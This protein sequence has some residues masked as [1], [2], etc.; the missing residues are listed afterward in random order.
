MAH[1]ITM[2][3]SANVDFIMSLPHLPAVGESLTADSFTQTFGGKGSNQAIA[4]KRSGSDVSLIVSIGGDSLGKTLL[5]NYRK[6][7]FDTTNVAV[8]EDTSC[9]TCLIFFDKNGDNM[10]AFTRLAN[11][12]L[13][14]EQVEKAEETIAAS[15]ILMMQMEIPEAPMVKAIEL[16]KKHG[17]EVMMNYAPYMKASILRVEGNVDILV[18]NE[19]EASQMLG[20]FPVEN[21]ESAMAA[22]EKLAKDG[23]RLTIVTLGANGSVVCEK[24]A[25][26]HFPPFKVDAKD[27]TAAGDTYCGC[28]A[29]ALCEG[30]STADAAR[31]ASAAGALCASRVGA[32]PSIPTRDEID[33]FTA[34]YK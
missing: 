29:T 10:L 22:A 26:T 13:S 23:Y 12:L 9:G 11:D 2:I 16:A 32:Q 7:G 8:H 1:R 5:E 15:K 19:N 30:M 27:A 3:G 34:T 24:G 6:M 4:A 21:L 25:T 20:D 14:V 18:V 31:F 33:A 28:F 17:V